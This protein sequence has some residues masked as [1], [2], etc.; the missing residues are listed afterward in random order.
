MS[1]VSQFYS[2]FQAFV[3]L[4]FLIAVSTLVQPGTNPLIETPSTLSS[5]F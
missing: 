5:L 4:Y 2:R 1:L 3:V